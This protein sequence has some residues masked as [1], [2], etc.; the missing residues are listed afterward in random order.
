MAP[1]LPPEAG[2]PGLPIDDSEPVLEKA[3]AF[4]NDEIRPRR[5]FHSDVVCAPILL[6]PNPLERN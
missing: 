1:N 3:F 6:P 5:E 2:F 4:Y